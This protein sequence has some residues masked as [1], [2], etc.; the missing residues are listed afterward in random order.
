MNEH[1][2]KRMIGKI[3]P[4]LVLEGCYS[5][6]MPQVTAEQLAKLLGVAE[7]VKLPEVSGRLVVHLFR[8]GNKNVVANEIDRLV[9]LVRDSYNAGW[10][11][12]EVQ[13]LAN[14]H[15]NLIVP[16]VTKSRDAAWVLAEVPNLANG[17]RDMLVLRVTQ[18][19]DAVWVLEDGRNLTNA[20]R[21]RLE[22]VAGE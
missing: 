18:I 22:E 4:D 6:I 19:R 5:D 10:L 15:R 14:C 2:I 20:H 12:R 21:A 1:K 8:H 7:R 9:L 13:N 17:H 11:L 16:L 3:C